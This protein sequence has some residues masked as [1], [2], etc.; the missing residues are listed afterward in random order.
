MRHIDDSERRAR[1]GVRHSLAR[2]VSDPVAATRSVYVLHSSDPVTVFLSTWARTEGFQPSHLE[3]A[4]YHD[5]TLVR[6]HGMRRTLWVMP[7][8]DVAVVHGSSTR[9]IGIR[10]RKRSARLLEEGGITDDGMAWLENTMPM[11]VEHISEKGE[12]LTRDLTDALP[13][14]DGKLIF[15]N[16]QGR[17]MGTSGVASRVLLQLSIES[18]VV[19]TRP[20]GTWVSGQYRWAETVSWLGSEIAD[21]PEDGASPQLLRGWLERFGPATE[22]DI[23]WWTGWPLRQVRHAL[24]DVAAVEVALDGDTTG[25]VLPDDLEPADTPER[26]VAMLPSLDPTTMGWK[27][28]DWYLG[29][30]G[31]RLFDR[32]GNAGPTV[33]V[34]GRVVGGWAQRSDG[35]IVYELLESVPAD[36]RQAID[37]RV[38]DLRAWMGDL[39]ITPRFRSPHDK[40]LS[41]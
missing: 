11:V 5:K 1:L 22:E 36:A 19:R 40:E 24:D 38:G 18:K 13:G 32:N 20:A 39:S 31:S 15:Y 2:P 14:L 23:R 17:L 12:V 29:E 21:I 28:R 4:L 10:E 33:W 9:T 37:R 35:E 27:K 8:E 26:W 41:P 6:M 34:D 16:R 7:V 3:T 25:F 30:H